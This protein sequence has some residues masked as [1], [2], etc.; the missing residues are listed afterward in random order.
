LEVPSAGSAP[1]YA[2][3]PG[4]SRAGENLLDHMPW[5]VIYIPWHPLEHVV[6]ISRRTFIR[7]A[8][9]SAII[10]AAGGLALSRV[11]QM[12]EQAIEGWKGPPLD[13]RD[14][15]VRALSYALLAPNPHNLQPWIADLREPDVV[16]FFCDRA[17]LLPATDPYARQITVGCGAFLEVL[18]IAAAEQGYRAD[19][20]VFPGGDWPANAVGDRPVCR[21]TFVA[22]PQVE[23]DPLFAYVLRRRTNRNVYDAIPVAKAEASA[24]RAA[25]VRLAVQF[26]WTDDPARLAKLR[27]I[28]K[29]AWNVEIHKDATYYESVKVYRITAEEILKHRDGLCFHGPFFWS[30]H[31][32]GLFS[33]ERAMSGDASIRRQTLDFINPQLAHS[34]AFAWIAT[35]TNDRRSQLA[36]G[37]AYVRANLRATELGLAMQPVSQAL[38][39]YREML[40]LLAE[41]KRALE[42]PDS[43]TVQ[44]FF[45]LGRAAAV[46]PSPRRA[47]DDIIRA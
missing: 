16:T 40:P 17:R 5:N 30:M 24:I 21:I 33:R 18:R 32:L 6:V 42:M 29:R 36:A 27:D 26:G 14:P 45:R 2:P 20:K 9:T 19:M 47:L 15:R 35:Q 10:V 34:P 1:F 4:A 8:G 39:E 28:A 12:P 22:E 3:T 41:L 31:A 23:R 13:A 38:E 43:N 11:D 46:E 44:M 37:A 25:A 7:V